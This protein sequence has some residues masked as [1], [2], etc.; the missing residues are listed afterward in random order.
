MEDEN[1]FISYKKDPKWDLILNDEYMNNTLYHSL[2]FY[3]TCFIYLYNNLYFF[4]PFESKWQ[5]SWHFISEYFSVYLL[6]KRSLLYN[7]TVITSKNFN[8][9]TI[10]SNIQSIVRF[11]HCPP[12]CSL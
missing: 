11:L 5:I 10:Y 4:Q 12:K 9:A 8:T 2:I 3:D 1:L 7:H 6:R